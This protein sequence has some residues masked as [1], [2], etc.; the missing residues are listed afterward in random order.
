MDTVFEI[1]ELFDKHVPHGHEAF[2]VLKAQLLVEMRLRDF[3]KARISDASLLK[4]VFC[5]DSP[6]R[7][8]K[9]LIILARSLAD[10]D[11]IKF[12]TDSVQWKAID[13]LN[14]LR[15]DLAHE[16]EPNSESITKKMQNFIVAMGDESTDTGNLNQH[17]RSCTLL[18]FGNLGIFRDPAVPSDFDF[19]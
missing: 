6:V 14:N 2:L 12:A 1:F 15:N 11:E 13:I 3:V 19:I 10:R 17:F 5:R 18:L 8:G 4:D 7:S 9:G 16:L